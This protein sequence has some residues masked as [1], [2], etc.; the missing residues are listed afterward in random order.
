MKRRFLIIL[1]Y[2]MQIDSG[3]C[4]EISEKVRNT[5]GIQGTKEDHRDLFSR[6]SNG[7]E[8]EHGNYPW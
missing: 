2:F 7:E 8:I 1:F 4:M 6:L 5:C 3:I